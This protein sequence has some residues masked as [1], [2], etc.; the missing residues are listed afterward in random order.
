MDCFR[1]EAVSKLKAIQAKWNEIGFV[2]FKEKAKVQNAFKKAMD[3]KFDALRGAVSSV[4]SRGGKLVSKVLSERD[5]MLQAFR[6]KE[7]EIATLQN[8]VGFFAKSKNA[9]AFIAS[10]N[11]QIEDAK[12]ELE[13]LEAKIKEFDKQHSQ[14]DEQQQ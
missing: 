5:K 3:E 4:R 9:E 12:K 2:P 14:E 11:S 13:Q 10:I 1:E 6:T 8:N 7:Q